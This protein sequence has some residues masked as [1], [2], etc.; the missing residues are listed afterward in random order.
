MVT[1]HH[2]AEQVELRS[3]QCWDSSPNVN[4]RTRERRTLH[5]TRRNESEVERDQEIVPALVIGVV[6]RPGQVLGQTLRSGGFVQEA[7]AVTVVQE[8]GDH[9]GGA[10]RPGLALVQVGQSGRH[11]VTAPVRPVHPRAQLSVVVG[12]V[13]H[14]T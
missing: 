4:L 8:G 7:L 1:V 14:V 12:H 11:H 3:G 10:R 5:Y 2:R 9:E 13:E 6:D